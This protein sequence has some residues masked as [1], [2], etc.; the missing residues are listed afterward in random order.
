V[1][2]RRSQTEG[3]GVLLAEVELPNRPTPAESVP[4]AFWLPPEMPEPWKESWGRW[5]KSGAHYYREVTLPYLKTGEIRE[6]LPESL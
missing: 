5:L 4:G 6:Y 1:L 3:A 2:A